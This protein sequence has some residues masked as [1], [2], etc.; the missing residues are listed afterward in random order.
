MSAEGT[1]R[2]V[3]AA[4]M[5]HRRR[6]QA[7]R[8]AALQRVLSVARP[9]LASQRE[10]AREELSQRMQE[11]KTAGVP[12]PLF[13]LMGQADHEAPFNRLLGWTLSPDTRMGRAALLAVCRTLHPPLAEELE[14]KG[15]PVVRVEKQWPTV[16]GANTQ[17]DLLVV[18]AQAALLIENKVW[19]RESGEGQYSGYLEALERLGRA[20][21]GIPTA[22]YL[23]ARRER[24][25]PEGWHG[26]L[27]HA[28]FAQLLRHTLETDIGV[29]DRI[30][31][32]LVA[33][34]L[35]QAPDMAEQ[36]D[37]AERLLRLPEPN[38]AN[39]AAMLKLASNLRTFETPW[40]NDDRSDLE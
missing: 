33:R 23:M 19:A 40:S 14:A 4:T 22:A 34:T 35:E 8:H 30:A 10:S 27:S 21:G 11:H 38:S 28:R 12:P 9:W 3:A 18:G 15:T 26:A 24:P 31:L 29:W 20:K 39:V 6:E 13:R 36:L 16:C 1:I 37:Q 25:T 2:R 7:T 32:T 17:P 5:E